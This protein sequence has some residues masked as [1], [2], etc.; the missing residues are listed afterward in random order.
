MKKYSTCLAFSKKRST[1]HIFLLLLYVLYI[2]IIYSLMF[3]I[4]NYVK[5]KKSCYAVYN[6]EILIIKI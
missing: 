2:K 3:R 5:I 6:F 1:L 4:Q